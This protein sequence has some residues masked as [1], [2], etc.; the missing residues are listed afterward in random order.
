M[1]A[2][3][4]RPFVLLTEAR[5]A[6]NV[7]ANLLAPSGALAAIRR[8]LRAQGKNTNYKSNWCK[9][10]W[11]RG[12]HGQDGAQPDA[13]RVHSAERSSGFSDPR[14]ST[15]TYLEKTVNRNGQ[16]NFLPKK[17]WSRT[18]LPR[19]C[20]LDVWEERTHVPGSAREWAILH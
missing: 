8:L 2:T 18:V 13:C 10:P 14:D 1:S 20:E 6:A 5:R 11:R 12:L 15:R 3:R 16:K 4:C 17:Q 9:S 19:A 7:V